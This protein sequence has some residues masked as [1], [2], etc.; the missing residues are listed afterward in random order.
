MFV[1]STIYFFVSKDEYIIATANEPLVHYQ[2]K[3]YHIFFHSLIV[4]PELAFDGS[5]SS[6]LYKNYMITR[7]EF[8]KILPE[9]YKNNFILIDINSLYGVDI[10][11]KVSEKPIFLPK[12]KKPLI[13]S[14]DDLSY[15]NS[16][17]GHGFANKLVLDKNGQVSTRIITPSSEVQITRDGDVIPILD[18]FVS[19]HPDF[20][21]QGAKGLIAITGYEGILGYR[22]NNLKSK[23]YL[24]DIK[25]VQKVISKL[26]ETGW[27]FGSHSYYHNKEFSTG[28][29]SLKN[30]EKDTE[31]WDKEVKPLVGDTNIF[32]GPF[33]EIFNK[34]ND[35]RRSYLVSHGFKMFCGVGLDL[36]YNTSQNYIVMDRADIDGYRLTHNN[37]LMKK[38]FDPKEVID[39]FRKTI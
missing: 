3:I 22:T 16:M 8:R 30:L 6:L 1:V 9:L 29:I 5:K 21:F 31:L 32:I 34:E 12:G 39:S 38:Y 26:K 33:G 4:Y 11:G 7:D 36:Y 14:L 15:Y 19:N 18:D 25:D 13:I 23:S 2:G 20:S 17:K 10:N 27:V 35:P 24:Q 28:V 37:Y